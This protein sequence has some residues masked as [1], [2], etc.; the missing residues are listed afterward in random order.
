VSYLVDSSVW[1]S[2]FHD[3][4]GPLGQRFASLVS[5]GASE[6]MG[7]P[8][9]RMEL[10]VDPQDFRRRRIVRIY[11][12]FVSTNI[13]E[14]DFDLA[15]EVYRAVQRRGHTIR[16]QIDCVI[17]A[18]AV[19]QGTTLVHNDVDFDRMAEVVSELAVLR[20]PDR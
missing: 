8:P 9:V 12:G 1:I 17:A 5:E 10:M 4:E 11:D 18:I 19:R 20:L 2:F 16:S 3:P 6:V 13:V 7:C 15:A 14:D